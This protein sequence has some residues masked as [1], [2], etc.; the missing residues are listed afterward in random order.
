MGRDS[1][2]GLATA[3]FRFPAEARDL[4]LLHWVKTTP[5]ITLMT[6]LYL[7]PRSRM[8]LDVLVA[9]YLIN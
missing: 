1:S 4:S 8:K 3:G 7:V 2:V 5:G 6:R 9:W